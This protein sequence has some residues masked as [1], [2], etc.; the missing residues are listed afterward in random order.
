MYKGGVPT[1]VQAVSSLI[2]S[3]ILALYR[4]K[5]KYAKICVAVHAVNIR[6]RMQPPVPSHTFGNYWTVAI[7]PAVVMG[8]GTSNTSK[9]KNSRRSTIFFN[10]RTTPLELIC[11]SFVAL[12]QL[13]LYLTF[14]WEFNTDVP[15]CYIG[16]KSKSSH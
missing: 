11:F 9:Q 15:C 14:S 3:R 1:R 10:I 7:A 4:S 16:F 8:S 5:P 6:P 13:L 12:H 2:W